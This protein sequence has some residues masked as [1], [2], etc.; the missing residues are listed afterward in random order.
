[1]SLFSRNLTEFT[2]QNS[3][4]PISFTTWDQVRAFYGNVGQTYFRGLTL[5]NAPNVRVR[6]LCNDTEKQAYVN[7]HLL[8]FSH[9]ALG[10]NVVYNINPGE[11]YFEFVFE[12]GQWLIKS[13][14]DI[15]YFAAIL[16]PYTTML[17]QSAIAKYNHIMGSYDMISY[18]RF[19]YRRFFFRGPN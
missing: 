1:M 3:N 12:D 10:P 2:V 4:P 14:K 7:A 18:S 11:Y 13:W 6:P 17:R 9:V 8:E 5:H 19:L 16:T 15:T